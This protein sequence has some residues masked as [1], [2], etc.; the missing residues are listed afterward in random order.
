MKQ[1]RLARTVFAALMAAALV[2]LP[3]RPVLCDMTTHDIAAA[4]D[5]HH[6]EGPLGSGVDSQSACA[7]CDDMTGCCLV[8]AG[9]LYAATPEI[10][11]TPEHGQNAV[12]TREHL[13]SNVL[14]PLTPPPQA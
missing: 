9:A 5:G 1:I 6:H 2:G 12:L 7:E 11:T 3:S 14:L 4:A 13:A 10:P 8:P